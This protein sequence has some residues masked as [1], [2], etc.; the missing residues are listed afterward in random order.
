MEA[1]TALRLMTVILLP[2]LAGCSYFHGVFAEVRPESEHAFMAQ[3][4]KFLLTKGFKYYDVG[5]DKVF[6][7]KLES[8][9]ES[10]D[11]RTSICAGG[12]KTDSLFRFVI[13]KQSYD[14]YSGK[15]KA[16]MNACVEFL[17]SHSEMLRDGYASRH[18]TDATYRKAFHSKV[19]KS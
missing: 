16:V 17:T 11:G 1:V 13:S 12:Y 14:P 10:V 2:F 15:E 6:S 18:S 7:M 4:K 3:M 19:K 5:K 9:V 8:S